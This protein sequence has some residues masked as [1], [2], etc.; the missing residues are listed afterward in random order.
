V[1]VHWLPDHV[2]FDHSVHI[3]GGVGCDKCH[4]EVQSMGRVEQAEPLTMGWCL[5][6]HRETSHPKPNESASAG[7]LTDCAVCHH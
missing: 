1:R 7:P 4:G 2:F 6:C 3:A 5:D